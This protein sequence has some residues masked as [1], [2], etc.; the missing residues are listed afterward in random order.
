[1]RG[2]LW[3]SGNCMPAYNQVLKH[4]ALQQGV[5]LGSF[6]V[7]GPL[8]AGGMGEVY[9]ARDM[10]VGRDG[11]IKVLP[12]AF[13]KDPARAARFEREARLLA[14]INHPTI[15]AIYGAEEFESLRCIILELVEGE[16]LAERLTRGALPVDESLGL[17]SQIAEAL[18]APGLHRRDPDGRPRRDPVGRT[19]LDR[20]PRGDAS[21]AAGTPRPMP[22]KRRQ[23]AAARYRRG[24]DRDPTEG[25][26]GSAFAGIG[27]APVGQ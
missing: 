25:R 20:D 22:G 19:G 12:E 3:A 9:R 4:M 6:E 1:P 11:A 7:L 21:T 26:R 18:E 16:T 15:A 13:A 8:G 23:P 2:S 14:A 5:R 24:A 10:H 17:A 27:R